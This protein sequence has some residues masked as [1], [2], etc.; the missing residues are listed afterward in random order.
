MVAVPV[1][2][3]HIA[4]KAVERLQKLR[5]E[6][7]PAV[8]VVVYGNR[9]FDQA[10][11]ELVQFLDERGFRCVAVGAFVGEHSYSTVRT[12]IA[13][14]RPNLN[15]LEDAKRFGMNVY[16]KLAKDDVS[17]VDLTGFKNPPTP[18]WSMLRFVS[19]ILRLRRKQK[20]NPVVLIPKTDPAKCTHCGHCVML[21][22]VQAITKG[23][24]L[25]TDPSRCIRCCACVKGCK[26]GARSF[27]NP[28][29]EPL[30]KNFAKQKPNLMRI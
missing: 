3:G 26:E 10:A 17:K 1:Y 8:A 11:V 27:P 6:A 15:D 23:D 24:E 28:Y 13:E 2:G 30:S 22:P 21:C 12:P 4:P 25:R 14:G 20:R 7:T 9:A 16:A 19:F 5:G 18:L 29:A